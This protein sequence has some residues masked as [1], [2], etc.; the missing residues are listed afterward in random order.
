MQ[1][2]DEK[3]GGFSEA[4]ETYLPVIDDPEYGFQV[5]NVAAQEEEPGSYLWATR[6][7][8]EARKRC[9]ELQRGRLEWYATENEALLAYWRILGDDR[10]LCLFNLSNQPVSL[11]LTLGEYEGRRLIDL[12][13]EEQSWE[14]G[15]WPI[16]INLAPYASHWLRIGAAA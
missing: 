7:L 14:I 1:W 3:N 9:V 10:T 4:D 8:L 12:L 15:A 11:S 5:V 13:A 16:V 2:S 6:F